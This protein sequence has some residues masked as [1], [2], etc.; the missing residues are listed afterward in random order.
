MAHHWKP[1]S[2]LRLDVVPGQWIMVDGGL[3]VGTIRIVKIEGR[4]QYVAVTRND[5]VL[6]YGDTLSEA[7]AHLWD[8]WTASRAQGN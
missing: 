1:T 5:F 2:Q 3:R 7:A 6:G 8:A 4:D